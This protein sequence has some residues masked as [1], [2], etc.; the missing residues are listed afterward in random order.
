[1]GLKSPVMAEKANISD[2][3]IVLLKVALSPTWISSN[4]FL[5]I[6]SFPASKNKKGYRN[7]TQIFADERRKNFSKLFSH[8]EHR[9]HRAKRFQYAKG[10]NSTPQNRFPGR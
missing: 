10:L 8:R 4:R 2:S 6:V 9:D 3:V 7:R 5:I 1:M